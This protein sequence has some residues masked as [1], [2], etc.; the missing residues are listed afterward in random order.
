MPRKF[1]PLVTGEKYHVFNRGANKGDIFLDKFDYLRFYN[2]LAFFNTQEPTINYRL[3][4]GSYK[5][6][7]SK[8]VNIIAYSL[9]SNHFHLIIE[10][11]IDGGLSEFMKRV[12]GGYTNYFNEK[13]EHSGTLLQGPYK[14]VLIESDEQYQY[15]FAYVNENHFVHNIDIERQIYHSSSLHYQKLNR[16]KL[17]TNDEVYFFNES[18]ALA[19]YIY[20][21]RKGSKEILE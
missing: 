14:R 12:C 20:E 13:N 21:K 5:D 9:L 15:L 1:V 16:S 18:R 3:A 17:I 10:P 11:L 7:K 4:E 2:S 8:L 6:S 19:K